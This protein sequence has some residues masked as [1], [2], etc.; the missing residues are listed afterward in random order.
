ML[1][2]CKFYRNLVFSWVHPFTKKLLL[3][4]PGSQLDDGPALYAKE[5]LFAQVAIGV[6]AEII[7]KKELMMSNLKPLRH[8]TI[9]LLPQFRLT[10]PLKKTPTQTSNKV[11][12]QTL[13]LYST[14]RQLQLLS[15]AGG[16]LL[17]LAFPH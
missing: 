2:A 13:C 15:Q 14:Q 12:L 11:T 1:S 3:A 10:D 17:H 6:W 9:P 4:P 8:A 5:M 7:R 16:T